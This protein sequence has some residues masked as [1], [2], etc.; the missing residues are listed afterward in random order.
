MTDPEF[1]QFLI[2]SLRDLRLALHRDGK[3][4]NLDTLKVLAILCGRA[5]D[6]IEAETGEGEA[7]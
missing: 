6:I 7:L 5:A 2:D 3:A 1:D 4:L